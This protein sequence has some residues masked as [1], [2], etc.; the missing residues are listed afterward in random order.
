MYKDKYGNSR[1]R[2][3]DEDINLFTKA[4]RIGIDKIDEIID[5]EFG[6]PFVSSFPEGIKELVE[7]LQLD[8]KKTLIISDL[9]IPYQDKRALD[10]ALHYGMRRKV[11]SVILNGDILDIYQL[12]KY[13][14]LHDKGKIV[15]EIKMARELFAL[16]RTCFPK[17]DI[18]FKKGNHEERWV[19]YFFDK[20][21]ELYGLDDFL[22]EKII[23]CDKY[24]VIPIE[25]K[26]LV[27]LGDLP[28]LHGHEFNGGGEH[29]A[30]G[31]L[32]KAGR[33]VIGGHRHQTQESVRKILGGRYITAYSV[34]C[35]CD[36]TPGYA[37]I[38]Q[39]NHGC[40]VVETFSN[41]EF[42]VDNK[43]IENGRVF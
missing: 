28:V 7:P 35:L 41:R 32:R 30:A 43:R 38:N 33:D 16:L 24:G 18:Y 21:K 4:K 22:L 26:R 42:Y 39:W 31:M 20:A 2:L 27:L 9:H 1:P 15:D 37:S 29:I 19:K 17:A 34:G 8:Y 11:D 12:S 14:K 40:A 25:D 6:L 36:L 10:T 3:T 23:H 13:D 5:L